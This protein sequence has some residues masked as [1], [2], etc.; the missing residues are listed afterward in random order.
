VNDLRGRR[1]P[2]PRPDRRPVSRPVRRLGR[3]EVSPPPPTWKWDAFISYAQGRDKALARALRDGL[4][5]FGKAPFALRRLRVFLDK[6][7]LPAS[8]DLPGALRDALRATHKLLVV[9]SPEAARS[10]WVAQEVQTFLE[11]H[12]AQDVFLVRTAGRLIGVTEISYVGRPTRS[13]SRST[14]Y[15][16]PN[17]CGSTRDGRASPRTRRT[18][19]SCVERS[20]SSPRRS[21]SY[22]STRSRATTFAASVCSVGCVRVRSSSWPC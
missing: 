19:R 12:G 7:A 3:D 6:S 18:L 14:G 13:R 21:S 2:C 9:C 1:S 8:S 22:R 17:P 10:P 4:Q 11:T 16:A 20:R 15:S 5:S